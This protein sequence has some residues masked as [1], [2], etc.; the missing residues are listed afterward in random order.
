MSKSS[1]LPYVFG[2][3]RLDPVEKVLFHEERPVPLTPKAF[4]TLLAHVERHGHLVIGDRAGGPH[5][6][7]TVPK[8]RTR[9]GGGVSRLTRLSRLGGRKVRRS[10]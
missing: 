3:F 9:F 4:E 6:I 2:T 10:E 7:E 5:Y 1:R 8:R